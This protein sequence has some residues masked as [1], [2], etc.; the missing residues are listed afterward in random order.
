MVALRTE[1]VSGG[2]KSVAAQSMKGIKKLGGTVKY[3]PWLAGVGLYVGMAGMWHFRIAH[4]HFL[5]LVSLVVLLAASS[6]VAV[7]A[8]LWRLVRG[9]R[10]WYGLRLL[11][12]GTLPAA[13]L[14]LHV[15][16]VLR[17][18]VH[19]F[20]YDLRLLIPLAESV[21]DL[22]A[23]IRYPRRTVGR[24]VVMIHA[25]VA[26]PE[27]QVEAMDRHIERMER[28][29][30]HEAPGKVHWVRGELLGYP[31]LC[32]RGIAIGSRQ[33][34]RRTAPDGLEF[35]D[36]HEVAHWTINTI[37]RPYAV[38]PPAALIEGWA[39]SQSVYP[40]AELYR[41]PS[42]DREEDTWM[43]LAELVAP[44]RPGADRRDRAYTQ[45]GVLVDYLLTR[46]SGPAFFALYQGCTSDGL[47]ADCQRLLGCDLNQ[48]DRAYS[49][50][51]DDMVDRHGSYSQWCLEELR[52]GPGVD[53][54]GWQ[55]FVRKY[56]ASV[57]N[58]GDLY[59]PSRVT[60]E[61]T[62]RRHASPE[63]VS[64]SHIDFALSGPCAACDYRSDKSRGLTLAHPART[65]ELFRGRSSA[66]RWVNRSR[67]VDQ[68]AVYRLALR[69]VS[70][71]L[72]ASL[73]PSL[74]HAYMNLVELPSVVQVAELRE[75]ME[76]DG[77]RARVTIER[78]DG[79]SKERQT[80]IFAADR[81]YVAVRMTEFRNFEGKPA[82]WHWEMQYDQHDGKPMLT[83]MSVKTT[84]EDGRLLW[85]QELK[86]KDRRF[87][88]VAEDY[89]RL[90]THDV[91]GS[92]ITEATGPPARTTEESP[93]PWWRAKLFWG[94]MAWAVFAL[95]VGLLPLR[96]DGGRR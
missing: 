81:A 54:A 24:K 49:R 70:S 75:S 11:A 64:T 48:L 25:G 39:Q 6:L 86:V 45:G 50:H 82:T 7:L 68:D 76:E 56:V 3:L 69:K 36:H 62:S 44:G 87:G 41:E 20:G 90:Q 32:L 23:R 13:L 37:E 59:N 73:L 35:V 40:P 67:A 60:L 88:P 18:E 77:P 28:L 51:V 78:L 29:L 30:G 5:P 94:F 1:E 8:G 33:R 22:E 91:D 74:L 17:S 16:W 43:P 9:P 84:S 80:W 2:R 65:W 93:T 58:L 31:G 79:G 71:D 27:E 61:Y 19:E 66:D 46:Y 57:K 12:L 47:D 15:A 96:M 72:R 10:R 4:P 14:G 95:V 83:R 92:Q 63:S 85:E 42:A 34:G 21:M 89:F 55:Q 38:A 26:N 53:P 52:C